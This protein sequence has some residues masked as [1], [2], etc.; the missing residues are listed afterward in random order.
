MTAVGIACARD[1][2]NR[3]SLSEDT[4]RRML[5]YFER[6]QSDKQGE[7][8]DDQGRG[9]QAW[10]GWGGDDGWAWSRRKVEQFDREREKRIK[11]SAG[12]DCGCGC[13]SCGKVSA[14]SLWSDSVHTKAAGDLTPEEEAIVASVDRVL[15]RQIRDAIKAI[16]SESIPTQEM[17]VKIETLLMGSKWNREIVDAMRPYLRRAIGDGL[18]V[19]QRT[20]QEIAGGGPEFNAENPELEAYATSESV[21]LARRAATAVNRHTAIRVSAILGDGIQEGETVD[22]LADRVQ[23]WAGRRGDEDRATRNRAVTIARTEA[24]RASRSAEV[25]A[26]KSTGLV[27]GKRWSLAPDPCEFCEAMSAQFS[28]NAVGIEQAFLGRGAVLTGA[29][30]GMMEI[31][32]EA[33]DGPPLHPNCRCSLQ[34]ELIDELDE[35][36][37]ERQAQISDELRK[38]RE[39]GIGEPE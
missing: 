39:S 28:E 16:K 6:H 35:I 8:W 4:V 20:V 32:Y 13:G 11:K 37:R 21:R 19:G 29:D 12:S 23:E 24:S 34:P 9:W 7:T 10:N 38:Q 30:G 14:K 27:V 18:I 17:T 15:Q 5:A 3:V 26:W 36:M 25:E 22:Q 2:Q 31:D 1:L 33:I